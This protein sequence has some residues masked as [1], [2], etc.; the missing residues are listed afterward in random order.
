MED[1][2]LTIEDIVA[3]TGKTRQTLYKEIKEE[4]LPAFKGESE[5]GKPP[6]LVDPEDFKK[7][8]ENTLSEMGAR[9]RNASV[10]YTKWRI[11]YERGLRG[12]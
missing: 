2:Y 11:E 1:Q 3:V 8:M 10:A 4:K 5:S 9:V 6:W 7:Y 12:G